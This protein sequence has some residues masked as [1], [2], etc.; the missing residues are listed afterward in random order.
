MACVARQDAQA[1]RLTSEFCLNVM[2]I[3][4]KSDWGEIDKNDLDAQYAF[5][6]FYGKSL[7]EAE[8]MFRKNALHYQEDLYSMPGKVFSY[9]VQA[10]I[11]YLA[12]GDSAGDSDGASSFLHMIIWLLKNDRKNVHAQTLASL[13]GTAEAVSKKQQYYGASA[14][15]YGNFPALFKEIESRANGV[16]LPGREQDKG[17]EES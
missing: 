7:S 8:N 14:D 10:F 11:N 4:T 6:Q 13:L 15:I 9:Y 1:D 3:P 2:S 16:W 5:K 17:A 12:S